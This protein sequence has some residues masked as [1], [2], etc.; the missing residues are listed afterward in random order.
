MEA[1]KLI[2]DYLKTLI[3][4][5]VVVC[6]LFGFSPQIRTLLS[7]RLT[8]IGPSGLT[9]GTG[10]EK[11]EGSPEKRPPDVWFSIVD[12][13][14]MPCIEQAGS[15]LKGS[16]FQRIVSGP[17]SY[18]YDDGFVGTI[19]CGA[20]EN[21]ALITVAGPHDGLN[22]KHLALQSAFFRKIP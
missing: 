22:D 2:L 17:V 18:G 15:A 4:P 1:A 6:A 11:F 5:V 10:K 16:G 7:E 12:T 19:W 8:G 3:W 20:R 13:G 21:A 9:F 14:S